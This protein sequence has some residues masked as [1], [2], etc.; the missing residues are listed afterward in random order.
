MQH[1]T[2]SLR[3]E[4]ISRKTTLGLVSILVFGVAA[5]ASSTTIHIPPIVNIFLPNVFASTVRT[6]TDGAN[7]ID[8]DTVR[9]SS[10]R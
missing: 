8:I 3:G 2:L 1:R 6:S 7:F 4:T 10:W 5:P 9:A